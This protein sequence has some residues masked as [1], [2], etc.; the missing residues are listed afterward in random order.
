MPLLDTLQYPKAVQKEEGRR[1][2]GA[3]SG[4]DQGSSGRDAVLT[5]VLPIHTHERRYQPGH[6]IQ[7]AGP[8][9]SRSAHITHNG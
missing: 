2:H 9:V 8:I 3:A 6:R 7:R 1:T 5:T 4:H